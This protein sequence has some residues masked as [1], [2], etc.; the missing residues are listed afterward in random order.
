VSTLEFIADPETGKLTWMLPQQDPQEKMPL[1]RQQ[2][3]FALRD[4]GYGDWYIDLDAVDAALLQRG[5]DEPTTLPVIIGERRHG[6]ASVEFDESRM[7]ATL[8]VSGA[9]GGRPVNLK[10]CA[11]VLK[12]AHIAHGL[13]VA[14]LND[15]AEQ[16]QHLAP[17]Q[18]ASKIVA[19]GIPPI[20]G[21][22]AKFES[23]APTVKDRILK[24]R[25]LEDGSVDYHELGAIPMVRTG[26]ALVRRIPPT[27]GKNG[28]TVTGEPCF[29]R[30][31]KNLPF[32]LLPG[33]QI[34]PQDPNLLIAAMDGMPVLIDCGMS[35][36]KLYQVRNVSMGMWRPDLPS[37]PTATSR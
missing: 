37:A 18:T 6:E 34:A 20:H 36:E 25:I 21:S 4:A 14:A 10:T 8:H 13:D 12:A 11:M 7:T 19:R 30:P 33:A 27:A 28:V 32:T 22:D 16:A 2:V 23:I 1:N 31:G 17:G 24:P 35:V 3:L 15:I 26:D 5:Q 9:W 29:A